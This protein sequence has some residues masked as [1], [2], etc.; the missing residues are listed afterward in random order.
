MS[1][2]CMFYMFLL[3]NEVISCVTYYKW[4]QNGV[5]SLSIYIFKTH[6]TY[7]YPKYCATYSLRKYVNLSKEVTVQ[8]TVMRQVALF[9]FLN[10]SKINWY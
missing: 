1:Y 2:V 5:C 9:P 6:D 8:K 7:S 4:N 3:I 10:A